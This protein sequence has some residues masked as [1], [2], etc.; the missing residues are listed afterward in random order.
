MNGYYWIY[1]ILCVLMVAS[2]FTSSKEKENRLYFLGCTFLIMLFA[3]QDISVGGDNVEY[4]LQYNLIQDLTFGEMFTHKFEF[5][6]V[7]LNRLLG[8]LF[9]GERILI[10]AIG[11]LIMLPFCRWM[12]K[13]SPKPIMALMAFLALGI[14]CHAIGLY[15]QVCA[16]AILT[17]SYQYIKER[18]FFSFLLVVLI[19][20]T[21]HRTA[22]VFLLVYF[23]YVVPITKPV[24]GLAVAASLVLGVFGKPVVEFLGNFTHALPVLEYDG[25]I[26]MM[27]VLW[28][29]VFLVLYFMGHRLEEP[30][31]KLTFLL[32]LLAAVLQPVSFTFA[33]WARI[34]MYFRVGMVLL[35]PEL[36]VSLFERKE[37][38]WLLA[39]TEKRMPGIHR[40]V[41]AVYEKKWFRAV[42]QLAIFAVLFIW[43]ICDL[44]GIVYKLAPM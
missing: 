9:E 26:T 35:V 7:L 6:Y 31:I 8:V 41:C 28:V 24:I 10:V 4:L 18:R 32:V 23:A 13:D 33:N 25:G 21:F 27:I 15:R 44:D 11:L 29:F 2:N 12:E 30:N 19:A 17:F 40:V 39:V 38:S 20:M 3:S 22:A 16:M 36:Y 42:A 43:F 14:Y 5:G 37:D 1:I 34:V